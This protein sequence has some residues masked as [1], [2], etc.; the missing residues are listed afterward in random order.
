MKEEFQQYVADLIL[1]VKKKN[2]L[3]LTLK[4]TM[5]V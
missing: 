5:T 2:C 3:D 4:I 1:I